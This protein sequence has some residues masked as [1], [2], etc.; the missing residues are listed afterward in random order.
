MHVAPKQGRCGLC[1]TS[2]CGVS[3]LSYACATS[4][5]HNPAATLPSFVS[6]FQSVS[7]G[8]HT[9]AQRLRL[10]LHG[11]AADLDPGAQRA[12]RCELQHPCTP[13]PGKSRID[14]NVPIALRWI[15]AHVLSKARP[16]QAYNSYA[17]PDHLA[18]PA[19]LAKVLTE[20]TALEADVI[21]LQV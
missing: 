1:E 12:P 9:G 19:R 18:W 5:E 6:T 21:A 4:V 7:I 2:E 14:G 17:A 16:Q 8:S 20:L 3:S 10:P 13:L 15:A 11:A